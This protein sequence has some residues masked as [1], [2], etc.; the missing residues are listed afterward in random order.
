MFFKKMLTALT[1]FTVATSFSFADEDQDTAAVEQE[2]VT[3]VCDNET[4]ACEKEA[5]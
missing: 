3:D 2:T 1:I 4:A 5:E